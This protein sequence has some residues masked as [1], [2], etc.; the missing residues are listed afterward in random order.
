MLLAVKTRFGIILFLCFPCMVSG[1][2]PGRVR[3]GVCLDADT[4]VAAQ[5]AGF[6]YVEINASKVAALTDDEFQQLAGRVAQLR[7]PVAAANVLIPA[8]IKIVGPD[9]DPIRQA[10]Y[11]GATLGRLKRL[12]VAV[13]VLGSG[14]ARRVPDGFSRD[15][16]ISQFAGF[17]RRLAS[18]AGDNGITIAVEPLRHQETN[19]INTVREGLAMVKAVDRPEIKLLV[20]YY[21][22]SEEGESAAVILEAATLIVHAHVANPRGR[23]Y[24]LSPDEADYAGF[25]ENL[26]TIGYAGRLSIEAS[27]PDFAAQAPQSLAMLRNA[28]ACGTR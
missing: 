7:I 10:G 11:L 8:A 27:T 18:L 2:G 6:D 4:F 1:Q 16:A 9:V 3:I 26:C 22:L 5:A 21:H 15:E 24:P 20:D 14:G 12:G 25:F 19:L 28:L 23:V 13:V 17:C